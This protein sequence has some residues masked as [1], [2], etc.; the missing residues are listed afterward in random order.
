MA[1]DA[2]RDLVS[3]NLGII[4]GTSNNFLGFAYVFYCKYVSMTLHTFWIGC[5]WIQI[6]PPYFSRTCS[7]NADHCD[8]NNV[9]VKRFQ[10][11]PVVPNI[12]TDVQRE[13]T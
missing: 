10:G 3:L 7:E 8:W 2:F 6:M 11:P 12:Y 1:L 5:I 4:V 13:L 9:Y